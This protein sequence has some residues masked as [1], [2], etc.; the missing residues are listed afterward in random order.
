MARLQTPESIIGF[1]CM[2]C[3]ISCEG[4]KVQ[5]WKAKQ[6]DWHCGGNVKTR[7]KKGRTGFFE[8]RQKQKPFSFL[9]YSVQ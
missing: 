2:L 4:I 8:A 1:L 9:F 7:K 5:T 6:S 3:P